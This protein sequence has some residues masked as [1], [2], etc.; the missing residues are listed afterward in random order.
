MTTREPN[1]A[2]VVVVEADDNGS[3][4]RTLLDV[5]V[6]ALVTAAGSYLEALPLDDPRRNRLR[7]ETIT[8]DAAAFERYLLT[9]KSTHVRDG[10]RES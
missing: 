3:P 6:Q 4:R 9:G 10:L 2:D 7:R 5:R 8:Q 1:P